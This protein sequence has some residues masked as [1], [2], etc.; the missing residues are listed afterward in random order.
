MYAEATDYDL[1]D[2]TEMISPK[3]NLTSSHCLQFY[4]HMYGHRTGM[5]T[6]TLFQYFPP[7]IKKPL[8][9]IARNQGNRWYSV[10]LTVPPGE[11]HFLFESVRGFSYRSDIAIDDVKLWSGKCSSSGE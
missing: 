10:N 9:T 5:G 3:V 7:T 8:F 2:T 1:G 11:Y 6:L 4:Y